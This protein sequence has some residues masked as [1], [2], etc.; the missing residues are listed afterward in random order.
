M[1]APRKF[2]KISMSP[3]APPPL[4]GLSKD[5]VSIYGYNSLL[6]RREIRLN[7]SRINFLILYPIRMRF[8]TLS[9][10]LEILEHISTL[11]NQ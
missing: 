9:K 5:T 3:I 11:N 10:I 8:R 1:S 6:N 4:F 7:N 2:R